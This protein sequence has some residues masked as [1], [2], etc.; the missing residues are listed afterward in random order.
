[1]FEVDVLYFEKTQ[2]P[3]LSHLFSIQTNAFPHLAEGHYFFEKIIPTQ[4]SLPRLTC[5][6]ESL[7]LLGFE[8]FLLTEFLYYNDPIAYA[9]LI[10]NGNPETY[11]KT[12]TEY[13]PLDS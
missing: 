3:N 11:L 5:Q 6:L 7:Y 10:L 9:E 8:W 13:K 2:N 4:L 1:M 12:V